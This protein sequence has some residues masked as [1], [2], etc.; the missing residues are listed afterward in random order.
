MPPQG[1]VQ[2]LDSNGSRLKTKNEADGN[3]QRTTNTFLKSFDLKTQNNRY[4]RSNNL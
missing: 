1:N 4:F 2:R 3:Q